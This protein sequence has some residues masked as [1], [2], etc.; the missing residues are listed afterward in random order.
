MGLH[1]LARTLACH[2]GAVNAAAAAPATAPPAASQL[3]GLGFRV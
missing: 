2:W 1:Y 3:L